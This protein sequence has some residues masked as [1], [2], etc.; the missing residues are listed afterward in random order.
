[1][2]LQLRVQDCSAVVTPDLDGQTDQTSAATLVTGFARAGEQPDP[3]YQGHTVLEDLQGVT[4]L[5]RLSCG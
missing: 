3:D 2:T 4:E 5:L 1:V